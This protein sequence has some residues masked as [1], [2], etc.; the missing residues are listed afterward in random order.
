MRIAVIGAGL[1][2]LA[3]A[4]ELAD[5]GHDVTVF[6]KARGP[7]G[8]TSS[9]RTEHGTFD[10]GCPVLARGAWLLEFAP[11]GV[12]LADFAHGEVP[13]PRMSALC[14]A[15][16]E[17]LDVRAGVR[18]APVVRDGAA[19]RVTD[20]RG[21]ALGTFDRIAVTAPAPQA[22]ELL[23]E[24]APDVAARA[25]DVEYDP[26]WA[27]L[28]AWDAPLPIAADWHRDDA[29]GADVRWAARENAKPGRDAGE[30]WTIQGGPQW[31]R[32]RLEDDPD[33][34]ARDLVAALG[35]AAGVGPLPAPTL[36]TAHRWRYARVT[37]ALPDACLTEAGAGAAGDW[38]AP[39]PGPGD[40]G[41]LQAAAGAPEAL[42]AGRSLARALA[43]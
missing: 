14:R 26:C 36:L 33:A 39:S 3:C 25:A 5:A 13:V 7:G 15:L 21:G 16:A 41:A 29:P 18:V 38:C 20:E 37:A 30:R 11:L 28:A 35:A 43:A 27:T 4:T 6:E 40:P 34:V 12:D 1:A 8:R 9:R 22:A 42:H 10:H 23:A 31:S 24:A 19:F 2:G 17:G 32:R